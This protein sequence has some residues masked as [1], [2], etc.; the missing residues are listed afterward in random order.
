MHAIYTIGHSTHPIE[1]FIG[2]LQSFD[3]AL[4]ADIR[5]FPGSR[6]YPHFN[7]EAL[8]ASLGTAGIGYVHMPELGGRRKPLPD[9]HNTAWRNDAFRGYADYMET[10]DFKKAVAK[11]ED[12]ARTQATAYMCSEAVWWRCHRARVSDYLK[13][14]GWTVMHIMAA[15]KATE[16]PYTKPAREAQG[17]LF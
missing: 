3:V 17:R 11:L 6:K 5:R 13:A 10:D 4:V 15:G 9:S 12:M 2:M 8:N 7:S 16:H 14:A 1:V